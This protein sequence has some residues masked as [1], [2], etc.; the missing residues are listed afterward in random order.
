M[1]PRRLNCPPETFRRV[2][3]LNKQTSR[4]PGP[5]AQAIALRA[6]GALIE[7]SLTVG[8]LRRLNHPQIQ[9]TLAPGCVDEGFNFPRIPI[10]QLETVRDDTCSR[11]HVPANHR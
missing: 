7:P 1:S 6:F 5:L 8:L 11:F 2:A 4:V 9:I 3:A 10:R